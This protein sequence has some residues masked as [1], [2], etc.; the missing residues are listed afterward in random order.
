MPCKWDN[1]VI[2][3]YNNL[4]GLSPAFFYQSD[5]LICNVLEILNFFYKV[6]PVM[7]ASVV[8]VHQK[9]VLLFFIAF[10]LIRYIS[11]K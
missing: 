9:V 1:K 4:A 5:I 3:P 2:S 11:I 7:Q 6:P 10:N 8:V